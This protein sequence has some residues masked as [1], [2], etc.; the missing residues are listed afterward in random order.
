MRRFLRS[1]LQAP[2]EIVV[3]ARYALA[4]PIYYEQPRHEEPL[5]FVAGYFNHVRVLGDPPP[6]SGPF[7]NGTTLRSI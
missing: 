6:L 4:L 2:K 5:A 7:A 1:T 3:D